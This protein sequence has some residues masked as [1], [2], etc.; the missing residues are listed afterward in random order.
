MVDHRVL[1]ERI[2]AGMNARDFS[3]FDRYFTEDAIDQYPQSGEL[4]RGRVN[5]RWII[6]NYPGQAVDTPRIDESSLE[7][8][9]G[10]AFKAVAPTYAV[11]H[12]E[13]GGARGTLTLRTTYPDSSVWWIVILYEL[14]GELICRSTTYFAPEFA[15]PQWRADHVERMPGR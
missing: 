2:V 4:V 5:R 11:V 13:G 10:G 8:R 15:A 6:E 1:A 12:V 9:P 3:L 7:T 14:R